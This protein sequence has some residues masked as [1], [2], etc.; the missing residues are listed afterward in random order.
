MRAAAAARPSMP[1]NGTQTKG[2][3]Y[4]TTSRAVN[5]GHGAQAST[6]SQAGY[7]SQFR[8]SA[9]TSSMIANTEATAIQ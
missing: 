1:V 9:T 2:A 3:A 5:A 6:L 4:P 8:R 7:C